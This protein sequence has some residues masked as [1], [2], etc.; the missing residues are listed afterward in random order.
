MDYIFH[1][2]FSHN[3][4]WFEI[5]VRLCNEDGCFAAH[6]MTPGSDFEIL[7]RLGQYVLRHLEQSKPLPSVAL[8]I[9]AWCSQ[10]LCK[11]GFIMSCV[12]EHFLFCVWRC[13]CIQICKKGRG[14]SSLI[15]VLLKS[16]LSV[17][18]SHR[19]CENYGNDSSIFYY[20]S[21]ILQDLPLDVVR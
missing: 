9:A 12:S 6:R 14:C 4:M 1:I 17:Y 3:W 15:A 2:Q 19:L 20:D 10:V 13:L 8:L 16:G 7:D 11:T 5:G 18:K 21:I